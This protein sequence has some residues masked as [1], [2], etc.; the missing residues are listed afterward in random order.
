M[1]QNNVTEKYYCLRNL[2]STCREI[3]NRPTCKNVNRSSLGKRKIIQVRNLNLH[4]ERKN[5][6]EGKNEGKIEHFISLIFNGSQRTGGRCYVYSAT[7]IWAK[8]KVV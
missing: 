6:G 2:N 5:T 8:H 7:R 1:S 3:T 4:N